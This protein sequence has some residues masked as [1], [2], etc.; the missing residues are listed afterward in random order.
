MIFHS[1]TYCWRI[2]PVFED[3]FPR[4]KGSLQSGRSTS[5]GGPKSRSFFF[6][7]PCSKTRT[8]Y[9]FVVF[10]FSSFS[11]I[12][13]WGICLLSYRPFE[14][15][16]GGSIHLSF[17]QTIFCHYPNGIH[18][19]KNTSAKKQDFFTRL[20]LDLWYLSEFWNHFPLDSGKKSC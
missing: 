7:M 9:I 8:I 4:E 10:I 13:K 11:I 19:L 6:S 5:L 15:C 17:H 2:F 3:P 18:F 14:L 12:E 20:A 16:T 1:Q